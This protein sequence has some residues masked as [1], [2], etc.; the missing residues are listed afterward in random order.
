MQKRIAMLMATTVFTIASCGTQVSGAPTPHETPVDLTKLNL[1][2]YSAEPYRY[3]LSIVAKAKDVRDLESKRMLNYVISS[4]DIDPETH[5]LAAVET[6]TDPSGPFATPA[7]PESLRPTIT[8]NSLLAGAYVARTDGDPR[9]PRRLIVSLLRFP[10]EARAGTSS[11]EIVQALR[12]E[13][14]HPISIDGRPDVAAFSTN[15]AAGTAVAQRGA[16]VV[17]V[18]YGR[19]I[20]DQDAVTNNLTKAVNLQLTKMTSLHPTP[21]EDVLDT[22]VD[23]DHIMRRALASETPA[24]PF[25]TDPDFGAF[26]PEG[27]LHFERNNTTMLQAFTTSGTDLVGRRF[28]IVYRTRDI[29]GSFHL[30]SALVSVGKR[31]QEIPSPPFLPDAR[32]IQF[33][34]PDQIRKHDLMCAVVHG[35]YVGVVTASS[36]LGGQVDPVL[37]ERAAAQ[38]AVLSK[39][40]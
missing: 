25:A 9:S 29:T 14:A 40:E 6:Y 35:R 27:H 22:P 10:S 16:Y 18:S 36:K 2:T 26:T 21:W 4:S 32:C 39:F 8:G 30:Q 7:L 3:E 5:N 38:Y 34:E 19:E 28:G 33:Y 11:T 20:P 23:P 13:E 24:Y 31:D 12:K 15:W 37:Y 1:G 17:I